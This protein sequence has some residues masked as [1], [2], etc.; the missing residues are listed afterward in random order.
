[1]SGAMAVRTLTPICPVGMTGSPRAQYREQK[2]A[3]YTGKV[4]F[5]SLISRS[6]R[7]KIMAFILMGT[8]TVGLDSQFFA[9]LKAF[10][11][12]SI[13]WDFE[14]N[15]LDSDFTKYKLSSASDTVS[16]SNDSGG[17]GTGS[18]KIIDTLTSKTVFVSK[19]AYSLGATNSTYKFSAFVRSASSPGYSG[20]GF[21]SYPAPDSSN[22]QVPDAYNPFRPKDA[23]GISVHGNGYVFHNGNSSGTQT[24]YNGRWDIVDFDAGITQ[25]PLWGTQSGSNQSGMPACGASPADEDLCW[26]KVIYTIT[27]KGGNTFDSKVEIYEANADGTLDDNTVDTVQYLNGVS[28]PT[29]AN[30]D[31]I[32][33]YIN[34]SGTRM[35]RFD[36][37]S[38]ELSGGASVIEPGAPVV[39]TSSTSESG[40]VVT[41]GGEVTSANGSAVSESGFVYGTSSEPTTSTGTKVA[42]SSGVGTFTGTTSQLPDG[43][44][45]FRAYAINSTGTSYGSQNQV[46]ITSPTVTFDANLGTGSM[47]SQASRTATALNA[48][49][50]SRTG[51]TF[52]GWSTY[53]D[54]S[55][56]D[57]DFYADEASYDFATEGADTL[58]AQ[59]SIPKAA[60]LFGATTDGTTREETIVQVTDADG[61]S[62]AGNIRGI[63]TDGSSVFFM[64]ST[65]TISEGIIREVDFS[66]ELIADRTVSGAGNWFQGTDLASRDLTYSSG[67][68]FVREDGTLGSKLYC[69]DTDDWSMTEITVPPQ[70]PPITGASAQGLL[71][72][73]FWLTGNLIDFPDGRIGAVS[74]NNQTMTQ[75]TGAGECPADHYCKILRLYSVTGEGSSATLTWDEDVVLAD[76]E[77]NWPSDDHGI[78]TDGTYLYQSHYDQGYKVFELRSG[79]PSYVVFNGNGSGDGSTC[80]ADSGVSGRLCKISGWTKDRLTVGNATFFGRDHVNKRYLMGD[81]NSNQ[82]VYTETATDQPAGIGTISAPSSPR[83]LAASP[84]DGQ[85]VLSWTAPSSVGGGP[86]ISYTAT[87]SPGGATCTVSSTGCTITGLTNG[88]AYTFSVVAS[89]RGGPSSAA[90]ITSTAGTPSA[91]SSSSTSTRRTTTVVIPVPLAP[92]TTNSQARLPLPPAPAAST[93]PL[94]APVKTSNNPTTPSTSAL[95]GGVPAPLDIK[96]LSPAYL[97]VSTRNMQLSLS[98]ENGGEVLEPQGTSTAE[99]NVKPGTAAAVSGNGLLPSTTV[100]VWLPGVFDRELGRL[101]VDAEGGIS[102]SVNLSSSAGD[103]PLPIGKRVLQVT[104][105]DEDGNQAVIELPINIA[106]SAPAPEPN[107]QAG[108]LPDLAPAQTLHT[109]AG[110]PVSATVTP[111]SDQNLL[112]VDGEDW[113]FS[114]SFADG[115][116]NVAGEQEAPIL[117]LQQTGVGSVFGSGFQPGTLASVWLF[118]DPTLL[119]TVQVADDGTVST[120][121]LVDGQFIPAGEH[122]L[123]IQAVGT[124]GY[125]KSTNIGVAVEEPPQ[126]TTSSNAVVLLWWAAA[127]I[128]AL[129]LFIVVVIAV[130]RG[131]KLA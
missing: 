63:T 20:M 95:I 33:A 87:A 17:I 46:T 118:S 75:G 8:L 121:F 77:S 91:G 93:R 47:S 105:F 57:A 122:T 73:T 6:R 35:S 40:G 23:L 16:W 86:I 11:A 38:V 56:S 12:E 48:N 4:M 92:S 107:R 96:R 89:N 124:D 82:F 29:L 36:N 3:R 18:I 43:T 62:L 123:Q 1:M 114:V 28:N 119:A 54:R 19:A 13:S 106:Q 67:C 26:F 59:W 27:Y 68:I 81:Y 84:S 99:L 5:T 51:L 24:N 79:E 117:T 130:R 125:I 109:S 98:L 69:I 72:G 25:G 110:M 120:N 100:Q 52:Q 103:L 34:F 64:P 102:G 74:G 31:V 2:R 101:S 127:A 37:F 83:S 10:A 108:A 32:Y 129:V 88:T 70:I 80:G 116:G 39:L 58:Y 85:V 115:A 94:T 7:I 60:R 9:N 131:R 128:V 30:A 14:T 41:F 126:V 76:A 113:A 65:Q 66:G 111:L 112:T 78:A 49:T 97:S 53:P 42:R 104:G 21:T 22:Q 55:A 61:N 50:F 44:Y 15:Q 90:A 71:A 45:Y